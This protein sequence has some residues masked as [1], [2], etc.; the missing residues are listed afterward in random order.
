M[1]NAR[2]VLA[3]LLTGCGS[4]TTEAPPDPQ[5]AP[6]AAPVEV[7]KTHRPPPPVREPI[8]AWSLTASDGSGLE[9][10]SIDAKAVIEGP[11][12]FTELH[13][14]FRNPEDRVREGTFA[15][16]LPAR[17][18]V[19]RFAMFE[20]G[21]YKE[22]EVVPKALARRAYDDALHRGIDPAILE[23][24]TSNEFTARVFPI[25]AR[26]TKELVVS[27]SQE[28]AAAGYILPLTGFPTI[29]DV[30]VT[31][32]AVRPDGTHQAQALKEKHWQPDHDFVAD[33]VTPAAVATGSLVAASF[34]LDPAAAAVADRPTTLTVLVDT[35]AS[36][37]P[38]FRR[39][40]ERVRTLVHALA[41]KYDALAIEVVA[42]DQETHAMYT[43]PARD[44]GETQLAAFVARRAAGASDLSQAVASVHDASRIAIVTDGVVT[45]GLEGAALA[46]AIGKRAGRVDV[47]LAGGIRDEHV[48]ASLSRAGERPGDVF[49]LDG[50]LEPIARGLGEVVRVDVPIEVPGATWFH[51]HTLASL[52]PGMQVTVFA[53]MPAA[54]CSL[55]VTIGGSARTVDAVQATPALLERAAARVE[56]DE[57]EATLAT[58]TAEAASAKLRKEIET[59]SVAA[60][61]VSTQA[62]MLVLDNDAE[63][64]RYGIDRNALAD[65]LVVG[66][67]GLEQS[68]RTFIASKPRPHGKSTLVGYDDT[69]VIGTGRYGTIGHGSGTGSGWGVGHGEMRSRV[70]SVPAVSIGQP[71]MTGSLDK[72]FIRR[73]LHRHTQ[74]ITYCYERELLSRPQLHGT[75]ETHFTIGENGQVLA[76]TATGFDDK[77]AACVADVIKRVD[78]PPVSG[79]TIQVNYPFTF[80]TAGSPSD[81]D[82][83]TDRAIAAAIAAPATVPPARP[84]AGHPPIPPASRVPDPSP[85]AVA[86]SPA[87]PSPT[88]SPAR[89]P[90]PAPSPTPSPSPSPSRSPSPSPS[91]AR[92][93][94]PSPSPA[95]APSPS[96][97]VAP[98]PAPAALPPGVAVER[99]VPREPEDE[100]VFE[101]ASS[102]LDG[103]LARVMRAI[104]HKDA[105]AL[106]LAEAWCDAQPTDVLALVGLGEAFEAR[107]DRAAAARAYGSIIDLYPSHADYRRFAGERLERL[108]PVGRG[109]A[110]DTYRRAVKDRPDQITGHRLLAYALLRNNDLAGAFAAILAGVDQHPPEGRF[111]GADRVFARDAGMIGTA[112]LAHGGN[113]ER[114]EQ[115]LAKRSLDLVIEPSLRVLLYW[116]TDANDVDLHVRDAMGGHSW[117]KHKELDSGGA[118]YADITTG[119]GPECFELVGTPAAGPYTV[120]VHYYAQG[121]MGYGMG[122]LQIERFDGKAFTFDDRPY[123]IM[124]NQAYVSLGDTP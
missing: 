89:S 22:A 19:S 110:I 87:S 52:R 55:A 1:P 109:L 85:A 39:Y 117:Y 124:K 84:T 46:K 119:F 51:P 32:D 79:S 10:V 13:L 29:D 116:E 120:G 61:L 25:P 4:S 15:I 68:H 26:D 64:A 88:P 72:S 30:S 40:L 8:A 5:V 36:R 90:S 112:Y 11:L 113:R 63:Y 21:H 111:L 74:K 12:A 95:I 121:P 56:I 80:R 53:R 48:A 102:A 100:G 20:D 70:A 44:F 14:R 123:I 71:S 3:F 58:T 24:S 42:F 108:G 105:G 33:V 66:P 7:L 23:K 92:S 18:T 50:E 81:D 73:Y 54:A 78:F 43:G 57:L 6:P 107:G 16:T 62:S 31:L 35:S 9:L 97:A 106:A 96:P 34:E 98:S 37:G 118:L 77:V 38:G 83:E 28:L 75:I 47:I 27:Y 69:N 41:D 67:H 122:L 17:A 2:V 49:D 94:S 103:K 104:A 76:V 59:R 91:P 45:A 115:A 65:I 60:R 114:I 99:A 101:P 93:P 86:P 82:A